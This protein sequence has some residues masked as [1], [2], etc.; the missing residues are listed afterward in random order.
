MRCMLFSGGGED[1]LIPIGLYSV[2]IRGPPIQKF[3]GMEQIVRQEQQKRDPEA[4]FPQ[5][6]PSETSASRNIKKKSIGL[7]KPQPKTTLIKAPG[8][9]QAWVAQ[10]LLKRYILRV[11]LIFVFC[12]EDLDSTRN[13]TF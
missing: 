7:T 11:F 3:V 2:Y 1:V 8:M 9:V 4:V 13:K 12:A 5:K 10:K 6:T